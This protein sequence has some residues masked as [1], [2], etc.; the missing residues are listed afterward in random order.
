MWSRIAHSGRSVAGKF[1]LL[2]L[3]VLA[4]V[5]C[6]VGAVSVRASTDEFGNL[7]GQRMIAVAENVASTPIVRDQLDNRDVATG[8]RAGGRPRP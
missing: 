1:L 2:N 7:R 5:L 6:A 3:V 8:A 4:A